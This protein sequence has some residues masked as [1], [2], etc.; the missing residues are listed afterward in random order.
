MLFVAQCFQF[1]T[2]HALF[3]PPV[4]HKLG[5]SLNPAVLQGYLFRLSALSMLRKKQAPFQNTCLPTFTI[6]KDCLNLNCRANHTYN[7]DCRLLLWLFS[8]DSEEFHQSANLCFYLPLQQCSVTAYKLSTTQLWNGS[9]QNHWYG[10]IKG[11]FFT[12]LFK[13]YNEWSND[14]YMR[15]KKVNGDF[16][17]SVAEILSF[18]GILSGTTLP[19][20]F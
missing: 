17:G 7:R 12:C 5:G 15:T 20:W 13:I 10:V 9:K 14:I 6:I 16:K 3:L 2:C 11:N 4:F 19:L 18:Y 1:A 8:S